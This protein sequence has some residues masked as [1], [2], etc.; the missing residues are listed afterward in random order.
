MKSKKRGG[1]G[2]QF[3]VCT[4]ILILK[5]FFDLL[6]F[7]FTHLYLVREVKFQFYVID[8]L[9]MATEPQSPLSLCTPYEHRYVHVSY[10]QYVRKNLLREQS[11]FGWMEWE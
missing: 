10:V 9:Y 11:G 8:C 4:Y 7:F 2:S 1:W 6:S 3:Y 5:F